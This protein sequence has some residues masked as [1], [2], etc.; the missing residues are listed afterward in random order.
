MET[1]SSTCGIAV[2][3][4]KEIF[5][6]LKITSTKYYTIYIIF[7]SKYGRIDSWAEELRR[8]SIGQKKNED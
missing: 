6:K 8:R 7:Q 2:V 1:A 5:R 3:E 4:W